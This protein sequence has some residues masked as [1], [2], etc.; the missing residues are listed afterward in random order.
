MLNR[1]LVLGAA[2][3]MRF[4]LCLLAL[5]ST[6]ACVMVIAVGNVTW[7]GDSHT[8]I[9]YANDLVSG[10]WNPHLQWRSP[11]YPV[12][13]ILSGALSGS[14]YGLFAVQAAFGIMIPIIVYLIVSPFDRMAA[15]VVALISALSFVSYEFILTVYHCQAFVFALM[16]AA[17][18][19]SRICGGPK[20][21]RVWVVYAFALVLVVSLRYGRP[22]TSLRWD[23][24]LSW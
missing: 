24:C 17:L 9:N 23:P 21:A 14:L 19:L 12:L 18:C 6:V 11:A 10:E 1:I 7:F 4:D 13:L 3:P 8:F 20:P 22:A 5:V 2:R 15:L 16:L